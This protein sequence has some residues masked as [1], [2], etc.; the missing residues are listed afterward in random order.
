MEGQRGLALA[1]AN[2]L[3]E[4]VPVEVARQMGAIQAYLPVR[5]F[6]FARFEMWDEALA[7]AAEAHR[8][9][10]ATAMRHYG[11]GLAFAAQGNVEAAQTELP[12]LEE[13]RDS[14]EFDMVV[15][16]RAKISG[17]LVDIAANLVRAGIEEHFANTGR[18]DEMLWEAVSMQ[19]KV[20]YLEQPVRIFLIGTVFV[21]ALFR[22]SDTDDA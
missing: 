6:T 11:R 10:Y 5:M 3:R 19:L 16:R 17:K 20:A 21:P 1:T 9:P 4:R 7:E 12:A 13:T 22:Q 2:R 14:P 18:E 15:L 8:L